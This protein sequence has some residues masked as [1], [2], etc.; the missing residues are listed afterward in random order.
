M[1]FPFQNVLGP[2]NMYSL[3]KALR[4][5]CLV[6]LVPT[7]DRILTTSKGAVRVLLVT[8]AAVVQAKVWK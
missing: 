2:C 3:A 8:P 4:N 6:S 5:P 7:W 1:R